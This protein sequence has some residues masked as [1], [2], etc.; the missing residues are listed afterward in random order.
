MSPTTVTLLIVLVA[1]LVA[2]VATV[3][4]FKKRRT[5]TLLTRFG[6]PE[7]SRAVEESG[8]RRMAEAGL[9]A[10]QDRVEAMQIRPLSA[11]D[12]ARFTESWLKIQTRFVDSPGGA[13][14]Q[15]DQ[16]VGDVMAMRGYPMG[17]F[18]QRAADISVDHPLV[19]TNY[20]AAHEIALKQTQGTATT[21]ELRQAMIHYR[22]LF[23]EVMG[24]PGLVKLSAAS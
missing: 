24:A 7:Y 20:R 22:T 3:L 12:H 11:D 13:V 5:D 16:L 1:I 9:N 15:A 14:T 19:M 6:Q 17:D 18:A 8:S 10:R 2:G 23:E 21:E 4:V